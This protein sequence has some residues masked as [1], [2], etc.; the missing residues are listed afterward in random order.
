MMTLIIIFV[1]ALFSIVWAYWSLL[2]NKKHEG[3]NAV[4]KDLNRSRVVFYAPTKKDE[5]K[6]TNSTNNLNNH[7]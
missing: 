1:I 6:T 3:L 2:Q 7:I 5:V 4:K